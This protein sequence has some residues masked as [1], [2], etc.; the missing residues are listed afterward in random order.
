[1]LPSQTACSSGNSSGGSGHGCTSTIRARTGSRVQVGRTAFPRQDRAACRTRTPAT[2]G[3]A[4]G[5]S[6]AGR[7]QRRGSPARR[8]CP[9]GRTASSRHTARALHCR[10]ATEQVTQKIAQYSIPGRYQPRCGWF[11]LRALSNWQHERTANYDRVAWFACSC[12]PQ[13]H[14]SHPLCLLP[15]CEL[16]LYADRHATSR[17]DP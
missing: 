11:L 3:P 17:R 9:A 6:H 4:T 5:P 13:S 10:D 8:G 2:T 1:M 7:A 15:K 16:G 12:P 14:V